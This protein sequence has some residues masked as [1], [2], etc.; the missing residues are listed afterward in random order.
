MSGNNTMRGRD[1]ALEEGRKISVRCTIRKHPANEAIPKR[2]SIGLEVLSHA[3]L[4][5]LEAIGHHGQIVPLEPLANRLDFIRRNLDSS[6][7]VQRE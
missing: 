4:V 1:K 7:V 6:W 2:L 3:E 5:S